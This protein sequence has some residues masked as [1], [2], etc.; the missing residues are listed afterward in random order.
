MAWQNLFLIQLVILVQHLMLF[1]LLF[2]VVEKFCHNMLFSHHFLFLFADKKLKLCLYPKLAGHKR[3][4]DV[5]TIRQGET[6]FFSVLMF[7]WG[8]Y[9]HFMLGFSNEVVE[10]VADMQ[11][12]PHCQLLV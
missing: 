12:H 2:E 10:V 9:Y 8:N 5:A 1:F 4:L 6:K 7:A 11:T 3:T